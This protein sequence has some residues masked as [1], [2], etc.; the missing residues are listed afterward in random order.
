M[1]FVHIPE[2]DWRLGYLWALGLMALIG[3]VIFII[4]R[5]IDWL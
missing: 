4:F 2:L 3:S 1:N 5:R